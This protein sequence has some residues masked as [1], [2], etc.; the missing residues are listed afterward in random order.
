MEK[1]NRKAI[2]I[3]IL[4]ITVIAAS[5]G[6]HRYLTRTIFNDGYANGNAY[7]NL[8]NGGLFCESN[9]TIF[10]SN[11][12][13]HNRLYSMTAS[14]GNVTK[15][16]DDVASYINADEHYVYYVRN[17]TNDG[18]AFSFLNFG[19]NSLCR[20]NREG[21]RVTL[22]DQDPCLYSSLIGNYVYYIHY[23][24]KAASTL[25]RIKIN[26]KER[27]QISK[28]PYLTCAVQGQYMYF[29][30]EDNDHALRQLDSATNTISVLHDCICYEPIVMGNTAYYMNAEDNYSITRYNL[31]TGEEAAVVPD[32]VDCY[33][34]YGDYIYYQKNAPD[35]QG[36]YRCYTDGSSEEL[37]QA[38][39]FT[40]IHVTSSYVYFYDFNND[41][42]CY[43]TPTSGDVNVTPFQP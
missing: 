20:I 5:F 31:T 22:L 30:G 25:Y 15:L 39:N 26:G 29:N 6:I 43:K 27:E 33:N 10:F 3:F 23:D 18:T 36:L 32:R 19:N 7:C 28:I 9:G 35:Q 24:K 21:G 14:G 17:N 11:P 8:Y 37:I 13:D 41:A 12:A 38:G 34:I 2:I 40:S 16:S 4:I 1:S 42:N